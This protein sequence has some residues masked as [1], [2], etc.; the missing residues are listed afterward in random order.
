MIMKD[1]VVIFLFHFQVLDNYFCFGFAQRIIGL[2]ET[3]VFW[4]LGF[5]DEAKISHPLSL[6][7]W[8]K[9]S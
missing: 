9:S 6:C 4:D 7:N 3:L 8:I 2:S 1:L 5:G